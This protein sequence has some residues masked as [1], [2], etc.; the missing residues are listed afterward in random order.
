MES[1]NDSTIIVDLY[2]EPFHEFLCRIHTAVV[3]VTQVVTH[4]R[5]LERIYTA[6]VIAFRQYLSLAAYYKPVRHWRA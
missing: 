2:V 3:A 6:W 4:L 5:G 1:R